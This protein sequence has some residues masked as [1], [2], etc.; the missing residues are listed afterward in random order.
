[1]A[2]VPRET[3][4][5]ATSGTAPARAAACPSSATSRYPAAS[6]GPVPRSQRRGLRAPDRPVPAPAS[7]C[8]SCRRPSPAIRRP[9]RRRL[10]SR[11]ELPVACPWR[12]HGSRAVCWSADSVRSAP[13]S[14]GT[15]F[16]PPSHVRVSTSPAT[17]RFRVAPP[18]R[19]LRS[20]GARSVL[21]ASAARRRRA[22][23]GVTRETSRPS[24]QAPESARPFTHLRHADRQPVPREP[25]RP[26]TRAPEPART[27]R[28]VAV[29]RCPAMR[30]PSLTPPTKPSVR[31]TRRTVLRSRESPRRRPIP[32]PFALSRGTPPRRR[33]VEPCLRPFH[34]KRRLVRA[35]IC[36]APTCTTA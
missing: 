23:G 1:M 31:V 26:S 18:T 21:V 36:D 35:S 15:V 2:R 6:I 27:R 22:V 34:V 25:M 8:A 11:Q 5:T 19:M 24:V 29:S 28:T 17:S 33:S 3:D 9:P 7:V 12:A 16:M 13:V 4:A 30:R 10:A 20:T 32:F 14:L